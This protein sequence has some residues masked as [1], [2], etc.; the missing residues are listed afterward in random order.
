M[1]TFIAAKHAKLLQKNRL[2]TFEKVWD[3]KVNWFEEPNERRGGWSGVGRITLG[4]DGGSEVGAF[5][6]KQD[7]HCRT[8]FMHPIKGVPT[9]QREFE[10]MQYLASKNIRAPEVLLFG[11]NPKGDLK[12]TL[13]T[14]ELSGF[15]SLEALTEQM[16]A[17]GK[18]QR[19]NQ[20]AIVKAV[21]VFARQLH[22]AKIQHRS[23]Y[24]K[25]LF[26]NTTNTSAP[27]VAVIDLEK[28]RINWLPALRTL[29]DLSVLNR[30]AK[31][32]SKSTRLYFYLQYFGIKRLTPY[33]KW[34]CRLIIKRSNRVKQ[35]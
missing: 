21:A 23:F 13:M 29:I 10:M 12:T 3:Y 26:V 5:L 17:N 35:K 20:R 16:F 31:Y 19:A 30:H 34:L 33:T 18:P 25:H 32:W 4:Q 8:S 7:N 14:K 24:P 28:S 9:F 11:R 22:T 27:E 2:D 6:K 15:Q 1:Q